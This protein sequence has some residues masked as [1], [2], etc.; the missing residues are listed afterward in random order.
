[1][2][3]RTSRSQ[4]ICTLAGLA[5]TLA[6][7][8]AACRTERTAPPSNIQDTATRAT[9]PDS[10]SGSTGSDASD[11]REGEPCTASGWSGTDSLLATLHWE[12]SPA[13]PGLAEI[14]AATERLVGVLR[15]L[16]GRTRCSIDQ[17]LSIHSDFEDSLAARIRLYREVLGTPSA[18]G[19]KWASTTAPAIDVDSSIRSILPATAPSPFASTA[20]F[21][22]QGGVPFLHKVL[23]ENGDAFRDPEGRPETR[24]ATTSNT[25]SNGL[26]AILRT[27]PGMRMEVRFGGPLDEY[28]SGRFGVA[29]IGSLEHLP[30]RTARAWLLSESGPVAA[31]VVSVRHDL[32]R[33]QICGPDEPEAVFGIPGPMDK[34]IL[35]VFLTQD[36]A[37]PPKLVVQRKGRLTLFD[38][39]GDGITEVAGVEEK[40][41][42]L[43][44]DTLSNVTW[45]LNDNGT[46]RAI[47]AVRTADC[48]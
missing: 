21:H 27:I 20:R 13:N 7:V 18:G 4:R 28:E 35:G 38:F 5:A 9:P 17:D 36:G 10:A 3:P 26:L 1:M 40:F 33:R 45:F 31:R 46:W 11:T 2:H 15:D 42:G 48:T 41:Q 44:N 8:L 37:A 25:A 12:S 16:R 22:F 29:G 19:G 30:I 47:D 14:Q 43:T 24:L 34:E 6:I 32:F 39:D 23:S